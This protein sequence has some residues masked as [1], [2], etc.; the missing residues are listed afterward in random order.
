M[1]VLYIYSYAEFQI[2]FRRAAVVKVVFYNNV[3]KCNPI[4]LKYIKTCKG[5]IY[6]KWLVYQILPNCIPKGS[7]SFFDTNYNVSIF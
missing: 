1:F 4:A 3:H 5:W 6:K 7:K 2:S